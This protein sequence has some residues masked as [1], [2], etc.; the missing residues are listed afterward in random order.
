LQRETVEDGFYYKSSIASNGFNVDVYEN[1][2]M[3]FG[4]TAIPVFRTY[5]EISVVW[6]IS[7][8]ASVSD[9]RK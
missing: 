9:W 2:I 8:S 3:G 5:Q 7:I 4:V 1:R 6:D